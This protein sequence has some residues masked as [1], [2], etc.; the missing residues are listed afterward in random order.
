MTRPT[1]AVS[2]V[3]M[4]RNALSPVISFKPRFAGESRPVKA[5]QC[6]MSSRWI[7]SARPDSPAGFDIA[8]GLAEHQPA[9]SEAS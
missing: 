6:A 8:R 5:W 1:S 3:A 2:F 4:M 9:A 7:I